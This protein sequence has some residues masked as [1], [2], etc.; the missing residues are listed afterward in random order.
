[1]NRW[2]PQRSLFIPLLA[3]ALLR[4]GATTTPSESKDPLNL[5]KAVAVAAGSSS[6][7]ALME[8]GTVMAWGSNGAG[9][10]GNG[11]SHDSLKPV[12]VKGLEAVKQVSAGHSHALALTDAGEVW[13]WG[14][15]ASGQLGVAASG[16]S[17]LPVRLQLA[18][19]VMVAA[20]GD[21]SF[22]IDAK[23]QV[24][25][26]GNNNGGQLGDG[27]TTNRDAPALVT[28]LSA[29]KISQ[30]AA[31]PHAALALDAD[32]HVWAWGLRTTY[33]HGTGE[34]DGK[35]LQPVQVTNLDAFTIR[36]LSMGVSHSLALLDDQ[37]LIGWGGNHGGELGLEPKSPSTVKVP[38]ALSN[39]GLASLVQVT[40]GN[41]VSVAVTDTGEVL[42]WGSNNSGLL[43]NGVTGDNRHQPTLLTDASGASV[44]GVLAVAASQNNG[45]VLAVRNDGSVLS[46]GSNSYGQLGDGTQTARDRPVTVVD[47]N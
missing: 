31:S 36:Q 35:E 15:N 9:S 16:L 27:T 32:G 13:A 26:W 22:A 34:W 12:Q 2:M 24:W 30:L 41:G 42:T 14:A 33:V 45:H 20:A 4:C 1:M 21:T 40:G 3:F 7:L 5:G 43:G 44:D 8:N 23:G 47:L 17:K 6:S 29:V 25:A 38:T 19:I 10:L 18:S 39:P 37:T 28:G 46:W 11:T